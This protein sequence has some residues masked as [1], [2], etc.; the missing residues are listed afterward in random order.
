[1]TGTATQAD[2]RRCHR[3]G[4]AGDQ[5]VEPSFLAA[6]PGPTRRKRTKEKGDIQLF[7]SKS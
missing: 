6:G 3:S 7:R 1:L 2:Q 4:T 5:L